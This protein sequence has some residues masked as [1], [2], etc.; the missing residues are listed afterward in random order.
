ME[1]KKEINTGVITQIIGPV[2][3]VYFEKKVP[4]IYGALSKDN[5]I[6]EVQEQLGGKEVRTIAMG[7]TEGLS[8]GDIITDLGR[9][10]LTPVGNQTLGRILNVFGEPVDGG[11]EIVAEEK[12]SIHKKPPKFHEQNPEIN[13]LE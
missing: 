10:I 2:V 5:I 11:K 6:L 4:E 9:Q 8:R 13:V 1:K 12:W 3:D 7:P